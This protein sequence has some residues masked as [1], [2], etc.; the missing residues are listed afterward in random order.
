MTKLRL[1]IVGPLLGRNPN[2]VTTQG[3]ILADLFTDAGYRVEETSSVPNRTLRLLDTARNLISWRNKV[4]LIILMVFSGPAFF[5]ADLS[6]FLAKLIGKPVIMCL[7][8]GNLPEFS[9]EHPAWVKRVLARSAR[10]VSPS[11]FL[12][13]YFSKWGFQIDIIPNVLNLDNYPYRHRA[14]VQPKLLWMRTFQ[15]PYNPEM[16]VET[17][18]LLQKQFPEATLTMAGQPKGSLEN[19]K[20]LSEEKGLT[21]KIRFAGFLNM[22]DKQREFAQHDI[23]LNTNRI[24]NMPVSVVEAIAFGLPVVATEV[25]GIP[26]LLDHEDTGLLVPNE[27]AAA[28]AAA[29]ARLL[30][31]PALASRLSANGRELAESCHWSAVKEQWEGLFAEL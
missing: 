24:D 14:A 28:M 3:E 25:G 16:A 15:D 18:A 26:F 23:Y 21:S 5:M 4:D 1:G 22:I 12:A 29:I 31:E 13:D 7:R 27:D 19:V 20:L 17:L 6:S 2:W 11:A 10:I 30:Q 8:G 9:Q